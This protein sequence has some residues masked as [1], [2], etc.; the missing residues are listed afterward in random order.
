MFVKKAVGIHALIAPAAGFFAF[1][2][3][4]KCLQRVVIDAC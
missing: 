1:S 4:D 2:G 3:I